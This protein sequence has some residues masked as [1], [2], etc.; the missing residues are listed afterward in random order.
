[1]HDDAFLTLKKECESLFLVWS[2][3]LNPDLEGRVKMSEKSL[4]LKPH[5]RL[6]YWIVEGFAKLWNIGEVPLAFIVEQDS[7][8]H[9]F[10]SCLVCRRGLVVG[11]VYCRLLLRWL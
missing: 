3:R 4:L 1:M 8:F 6:L 11:N 9:P 5:G 10:L 2:K 7:S